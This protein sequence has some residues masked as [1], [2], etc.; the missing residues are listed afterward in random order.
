MSIYSVLFLL[1]VFI[2][3]RIVN[4]ENYNHATDNS[5]KII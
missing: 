2:E 1:M 4:R 5:E 3:E